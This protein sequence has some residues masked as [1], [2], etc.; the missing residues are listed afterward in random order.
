[1][2][3][4]TGFYAP[5]KPFLVMEIMAITSKPSFLPLLRTSVPKPLGLQPYPNISN[6]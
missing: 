5:I 4:H 6:L 1:M 3:D 2:S